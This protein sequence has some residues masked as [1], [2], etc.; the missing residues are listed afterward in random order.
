MTWRHTQIYSIVKPCAVQACAGFKDKDP[1]V[2]VMGKDQHLDFLRDEV[3]SAS[4]SEHCH[5]TKARTV[6]T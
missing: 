2:L 6:Q 5:K 4:A 3:G 1:S